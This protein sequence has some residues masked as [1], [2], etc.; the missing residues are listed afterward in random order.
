[1]RRLAFALLRC[2]PRVGDDLLEHF[3]FDHTR[4]TEEPD[5][6]SGRALKAEGIGL[7]I[8]VDQH[9]RDGLLMRLQILAGLFLVDA[10]PWQK[11]PNIWGALFFPCAPPSR[12]PPP[13]FFFVF[14]PPLPLTR[15]V[16]NQPHY[17][18][19]SL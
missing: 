8:V 9:I 4:H 11:F 6:E 17:T 13:L 5:D 7:G 16:C 19:A 1:M 3:H 15:P 2:R 14:F 12:L 10:R 18:P